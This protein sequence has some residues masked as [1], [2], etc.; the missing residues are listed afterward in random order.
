MKYRASFL[1]LNIQLHKKMKKFFKL[2]F[3][4]SIS[5][6]ISS[7]SQTTF[8]VK[9]EVI[10]R[11]TNSPI[12]NAEVEVNG[13][14]F[15]YS[16]I[17][18]HYIVTAQSYDQLVV[19]HPDFQ[20]VFYTIKDDEEIKIMVEGFN[21]ERETK[22]KE[23]RSFSKKRASKPDLYN[24]HLDSAKFYK[25]KDIDKGLSF[26]EKTLQEKL[27]KKR[28]ASSFEVLADI[29]LHWKQYDLAIEN[30]KAS[31]KEVN[32]PN[33][34]VQLAKAYYLNKEYS[35]SEQSFKKSL[36]NKLSDYKKLTAYE[37]LGDVFVQT[38]NYNK[39]KTN[40]NTALEIAKKNSVT[41]KITDLNS[42]LAEVFSKE[43]KNIEADKRFKNSLELANKEN[44]KRSLKEQQKVADF[45]NKSRRYDEEIELR[46]ESLKNT[47]DVISEDKESLVDSITSQ[48]INYKIGNAYVE[49]EDYQGA[50]PYLEKSI[51]DAN[52]KEDLII[53]QV[54]TKRLSEVYATVGDYT[55]ALE[56]YREYVELVDKS[57]SKKQQEIYQIKRFSKRISENQ[58]RISSLEKDKE[59]SDSKIELAYKDQELTQESNKLQKT[60]I[61]SLLAVMLLFSLLAYFMY[62]NIKQQK[63]AN[64]LL[65]LKSMR[66]QMNPHFIFNAL[67]SVNSFI[68]VNDERSAN[69]YLSE[70]SALMR[71]V[72][73]NSDEDFIPLTKEIELLEL[74]VKLEHNR[75][76]DKFEYTIN[77]DKEI[78][79]ANF[80]I[81]PMLLQPYIENAI[82]HGLRYKKEKGTLSISM[83]QKTNDI[84]DIIIEDNGVGR[85]KSMEMKTKNQ[86]KQKSK[87]MSTIKNRIAILNDMYKDKVTVMI[88]DALPN[89]TGTKVTLTLKRN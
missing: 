14:I 20:T 24:Q 77:I 59:L 5:S 54:A 47:V 82:W 22:K 65:A 28:R 89:E 15:D 11:E 43:G 58:N 61:Y 19:T 40:Y 16:S 86:L 75:F 44:V 69:R 63:L 30:Y 64:N 10:D 68:A 38:K 84:I 66:S 23:I 76:K 80:S 60:I 57:Y 83:N 17:K 52:K 50:I 53:A 21:G 62:R 56:S 45:Y 39:A 13:T 79:L 7:F 41:P 72:L 88:N 4:I 78:Q 85:K 33:V 87:G 37:G 74:Y 8:K 12:K 3:F 46:K 9:V 35:K 31:L 49:K 18:G 70:F 27:T 81:P 67:N 26:I 29:Y 51:T 32:T 1:L 55:K 2:F 42:K 73:E 71:S 25:K 34:R 48:K 36:S 6:T